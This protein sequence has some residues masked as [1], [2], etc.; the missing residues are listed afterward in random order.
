MRLSYRQ[1]TFISMGSVLV[2]GTGLSPA[3]AQARKPPPRGKLDIVTGTTTGKELILGNGKGRRVDNGEDATAMGH[4]QTAAS[5]MFHSSR[6]CRSTSDAGSSNQLAQR[7]RSL[8]TD[9]VRWFSL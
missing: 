8:C 6:R 2:A 1:S 9:D 3:P 4:V 7:E 5:M